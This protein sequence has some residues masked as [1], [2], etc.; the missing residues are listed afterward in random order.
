MEFHPNKIGYL[1]FATD[2]K[3]SPDTLR[4]GRQASTLIIVEPNT[5]VAQLLSEYSVF[6]PQVIDPSRCC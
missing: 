1:P 6:L 3:V 5:P 4:L 2:P